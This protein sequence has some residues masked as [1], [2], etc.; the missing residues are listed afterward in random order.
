MDLNENIHSNQNQIPNQN[1]KPIEENEN[2]EYK[3]LW[4]KNRILLEKIKTNNYQLSM[5]IENKYIHLMSIVDFDLLKLLYDLNQ[6]IYEKIVF[7]KIKEKEV[8]ATLLMKHF[9]VD[10]GFPQRYSF[11]HIEK[12]INK[13][14]NEIEFY[15][16]PI[17]AER[18][19]SIS[20][21][22]VAVPLEKMITKGEMMNDS[23]LKITCSIFFQENISFPVF[24]EKLV[25][26]IIFKIFNRLKQVIEK[27]RI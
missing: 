13:E 9:F 6:D 24:L 10:L 26:Q 12:K 18:P 19:D 16:T 25:G 21:S 15:S 27:V 23:T 14:K 20:S 8:I 22:C 2:S 7:E 5:E 17:Y 4:N 3:I 11:M 1:Q